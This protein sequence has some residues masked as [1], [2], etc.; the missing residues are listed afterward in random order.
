MKR[1]VLSVDVGGTN[2]KIGLV[3]AK[4]RVIFRTGLF[5][6][7]FVRN[8]RLLIEA[9]VVRLREII[10]LNRLKK[11]DILGIG[12]GL[13]GLIDF[14]KGIVNTLVNIPGWRH[15]PLKSILEKKL[16]IPTFIDNDVNVMTL[17]EWR[18]GAG[19]GIS[20]M[21]CLTLGTG[22][23]G[24]LVVDGKIYRGET[25]SAGEL[26]H[27]PLNEKG[28]KCNCGGMGCLES[29]IGNRY[30]L[31]SAE[32]IFRKNISLEEITRLA[33]RG[34]AKA[35]RFWNMVGTHLGNSLVGLVNLLNPKKIIIGGGISNAHRHFLKTVHQTIRRRS[36]RIPA[37]AVE[38]VK[39]KLGD[40]AGMI[41]A[42]V[43]V[44][45][46]IHAR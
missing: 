28:P 29:Y 18:F 30:L 38:V 8:K 44:Y 42:Y 32:K 26:G 46:A 6:R 22:V 31:K 9:I 37:R 1:F 2:I 40:D 10:T 5:T 14:K 36:M 15:V 24:G 12:I 3:D 21:V 17:G 25:F 34:H 20:N 13:P 45:D 33:D 39:A 23:G 27:V 11:S 7:T 19:R 16:K 35:L 4:G 43:L 41:G